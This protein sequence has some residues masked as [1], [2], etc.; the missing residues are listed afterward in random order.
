MQP[1]RPPNSPPDLPPL[2]P[3]EY[4]HAPIDFTGTTISTRV[5]H[6]AWTCRYMSCSTINAIY[7]T[8][9]AQCGTQRQPGADALGDNNTYIGF[10][11][12]VDQSD[13][14]H[15]HYASRQTLIQM[16]QGIPPTNL[17]RIGSSPVTSWRSPDIDATN[18]ENS[19]PPSERSGEVGPMDSAPGPSGAGDAVGTNREART[20]RTGDGFEVSHMARGF[21][22][23]RREEV[24]DEDLDEPGEKSKVEDLEKPD[25]QP[26]DE[27]DTKGGAAGDES[28]NKRKRE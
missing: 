22:N 28:G 13:N 19:S 27:G 25:K 20:V 17:P 7:Q 4:P 3:P 26:E 6:L 24:D 2:D 8:V 9:C 18:P 16:S 23:V 14:E 15:W 21:E 12:A 10:L 11:Q 1:T 5:D